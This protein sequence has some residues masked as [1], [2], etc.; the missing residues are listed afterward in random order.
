MVRCKKIANQFLVSD[1]FCVANLWVEKFCLVV[2]PL[3]DYKTVE[4]LL[5]A[6]STVVVIPNSTPHR[7]IFSSEGPGVVSVHHLVFIL[8]LLQ[9]S[10]C[11]VLP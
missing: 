11:P 7:T 8:Q 5:Q 4:L 1:G 3:S 9:I 6:N 10:R 2:A